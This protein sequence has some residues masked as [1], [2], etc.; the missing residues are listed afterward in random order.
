IASFGLNARRP[1]GFTGGATAVGRINYD[2]HRNSVGRH[3]N[4]PVVLMQAFN[5]GGQSGG[6]ATIAGDCTAPGSE[7]PPTDMSVLVYVEDNADPGAGYDVF[8]IFFCT[9]GPSLPGPGFSGMTAPSGCD[10]PEG[11]TLRT[12]NIQVRTDAGVLGEQT[13]TAAAAGIFPTTPTFNGVDLAGGIYGVGV[14]AGTDSTYGDLHAEFTVISPLRLYQSISVDGWITSGSIAGG[15]LTFSGTATLDMGEGPPPTGGLALSGCGGPA[16]GSGNETAADA[17]NR[18]LAAHASGKLDDAVAAYFTT[19][20]KDPKSQFAYYN[21]GEI[22]QRQNRFVAAESYYRLALEMD[23]KMVSALFNLAIVRTNAGATNEAIALYR[24]AIAVDANYAAA[25][26]N[27][28]LLLRQIG[29]TA[30]AQTELATAQ[31]LDPTLVAPSPSASPI[32][33]AS[34]SP[35]R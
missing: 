6:S 26:F 4:A 34:P 22:A 9:L 2:R 1:P 20:S 27:L 23:P 14:R 31:K 30:E 13:S 16:S 5:S 32:R 8:R 3:V 21:L 35:T 12:G 17:L 15:T 10:G 11:G 24:Q 25:H 18:G 29:Q 28:G 19:L 7:C 33:Q